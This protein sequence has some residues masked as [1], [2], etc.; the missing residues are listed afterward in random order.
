MGR[1]ETKF[2][3]HN[4]RREMFFFLENKLRKW[5]EN[6]N[7][8]G[9]NINMQNKLDMLFQQSWVIGRPNLTMME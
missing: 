4:E 3:P 7:K 6:T 1:G 8:V 5:I 9:N 2:V